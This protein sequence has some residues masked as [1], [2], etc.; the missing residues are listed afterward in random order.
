MADKLYPKLFPAPTGGLNL[1]DPLYLLP[2]TEAPFLQNFFPETQYLRRRKGV[3]FLVNAV[4]SGLLTSPLGYGR[5]TGYYRFGTHNI[6]SI[7][8]PS[9][10]GLVDIPDGGT[11]TLL[12]GGYVSGFQNTPL[13]A[14]EFKGFVILA[15]NFTV[16]KFD[17]TTYTSLYG[18]SG[19]PIVGTYR[20]RLYYA[21]TIG[22]I[23]YD[24]PDSIGGTLKTYS[25]ERYL[26]MSPSEPPVPVFVGAINGF[27]GGI[28]ESLFAAIYS[29]GEI[30]VFSGEYPGSTTWQLVAR[31]E[32]GQIRM[33]Y[34]VVKVLSDYWVVTDNG[35]FSLND[36]CQSQQALG[37]DHFVTSKVRPIFDL[38]KQGIWNWGLNKPTVIEGDRM[39]LM[40]ISVPDIVGAYGDGWLVINIDTKA[41]TIFKYPPEASPETDAIAIASN[42]CYVFPTPGQSSAG[43]KVSICQ[44]EYGDSDLGSVIQNLAVAH[45]F[46]DCGDYANAK[47]A[48]FLRPMISAPH[49]SIIQ[50]AIDSNFRTSSV[51]PSQIALGSSDP[52]VDVGACGGHGCYIRPRISIRGD[53]GASNAETHARYYG[54]LLLY[55][56]GGKL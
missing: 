2:E 10:I 9:A 36:L 22:Q 11:A 19:C 23:K 37:R 4:D 34:A 15:I 7:W 32:V 13:H 45:A 21:N 24:A 39:F 47:T 35:I 52:S 43:K 49:S 41:A 17:G 1:A 18:T 54:S 5:I 27:R 30:L 38:A 26:K 16:A 51:Y 8:N 6:L 55:S 50:G 48:Q 31:Y 56:K 46:S 29:T 14:V 28:G 44:F 3:R 20:G 12:G 25:V 42:G 40:R 33:E 53:S